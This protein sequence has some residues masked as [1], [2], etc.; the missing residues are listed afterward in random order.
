MVVE[1]DADGALVHRAH[2]PA[3]LQGMDPARVIHI[4]SFASTLFPSL[5]IGYLVLPP[6][7]VAAGREAKWSLDLPNATADQ[8]VVARFIAK[9]FYDR[10]LRTMRGVY[11]RAR[12]MLEEALARHFGDQVSVL[13]AASGLHLCAQFSGVKF[14]AKVLNRINLAG[15]GVYPVEECALRKGRW[16]NALVLGYGM[17]DTRRIST[18]I[19]ILKR[20]VPS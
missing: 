5:A 18:G 7:L 8:L 13:G 19:S 12:A 4:G 17:L 6:S 15:V 10:Y 11:R 20:C 1:N 2:P 14:T 9:G 3:A 16:E